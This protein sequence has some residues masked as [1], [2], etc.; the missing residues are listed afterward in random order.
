MSAQDEDLGCIYYT[1]EKSGA[2]N[3]IKQEGPSPEFFGDTCHSEP[4]PQLEKDR[5]H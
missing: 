2:H 4:Q 1:L 3:E 5:R